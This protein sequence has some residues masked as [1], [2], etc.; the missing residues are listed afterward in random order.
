[1]SKLLLLMNS[2][3]ARELLKVLAPT[4]HFHIG[5]VGAIP[6]VETLDSLDENLSDKLATHARA[7]WDVQETSWGFGENPLVRIA[8]SDRIENAAATSGFSEKFH[9][10]SNESQ[11]SSDV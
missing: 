9:D 8:V 7:D 11:S 10:L 5:Y 1:M 6:V 2:A 4:M 3:V